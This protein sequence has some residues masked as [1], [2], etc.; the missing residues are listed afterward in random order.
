MMNLAVKY[1]SE[2]VM[3]QQQVRSGAVNPNFED[4]TEFMF[5]P[6]QRRLKE[7]GNR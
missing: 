6:N 4:F 3:N 1:G 7:A 2:D 5:S